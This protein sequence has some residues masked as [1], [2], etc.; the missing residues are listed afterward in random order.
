[1]IQP[2]S[3]KTKKERKTENPPDLFD[4]GNEGSVQEERASAAVDYT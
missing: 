4:G 1:M 3:K 2:V